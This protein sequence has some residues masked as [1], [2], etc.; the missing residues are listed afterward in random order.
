[1]LQSSF[2]KIS[3]DKPVCYN[4]ITVDVLKIAVGC[5]IKVPLNNN[6]RLLNERLIKDSLLPAYIGDK[7]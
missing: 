5:W 7:F 6:F 2:I 3:L 1:M 4:C